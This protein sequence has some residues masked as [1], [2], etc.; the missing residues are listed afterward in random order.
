MI[1]GYYT[2]WMQQLLSWYVEDIDYKCSFKRAVGSS[3]QP[4][5]STILLWSDDLVHI[6][7]SKF[8]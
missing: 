2:M 3:L 8:Y 5:E 7:F 1:Q 4:W 6:S